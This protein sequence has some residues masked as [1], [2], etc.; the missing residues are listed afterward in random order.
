[1]PLILAAKLVFEMEFKIEYA[2]VMKIVEEEVSREAV[3]AVSADGVSLYDGIRMV[4]RDEAK[5]KRLMSEALVLVRE[6]CNRFVRH[7][8]LATTGEDD[9]SGESTSFCFELE[10]SPRRAAGKE[11]SLKTLF[12]SMTANFILNRYFA[13]KNLAELASKYDAAALADVQAM[14][15][16]LYTKLPPVYPAI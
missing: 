2:P 6:Q 11:E 7:A 5:K 16:L 3:Q 14:T 13:S 4:S 9:D 15:R 1:M 8:A 12:R 10:L